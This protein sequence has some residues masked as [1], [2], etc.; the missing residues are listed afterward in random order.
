MND[1]GLKFNEAGL[2]PAVVQDSSSGKV[3]ML[4]YMNKESLDKT[5]ET[6]FTWFYSRSRQ[7]L[8][9]KGATSGNAQKVI[10]ISYDCDGDSLLLKVRQ[11]GSACHTGEESCFYRYLDGEAEAQN[12]GTV[13]IKLY[14]RVED[15]RSNPV[16]GSY[17]SYLFQKGS[18]KI[19]KKLGEECAEII[20][21]AK[22]SS[23]SE[24]VYEIADM[25]YHL[26]VLMANEG[27]EYADI[28][29]ELKS[30]YK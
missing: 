29:E 10:S 16:E 9:N 13:L 20:I 4:A 18:D 11:T 3:L 12:I 6:G 7:E 17:T 21:A 26:T 23:K 2:I 25:L 14:S 1:I 30:R 28:A 27:I 24:A 8:W 15:R 22:N 5:L 19:L